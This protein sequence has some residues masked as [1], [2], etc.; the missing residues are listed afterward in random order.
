MYYESKRANECGE[1]TT[2]LTREK[3][4][5][6]FR[7]VSFVMGEQYAMEKGFT[8][9]ERSIEVSAFDTSSLTWK[10]I[11]PVGMFSYRDTKEMQEEGAAKMLKKVGSFVEDAFGMNFPC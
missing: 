4:T 1:V 9:R 2:T 5:M 8:P 3:D 11:I 7:I 6:L 10:V